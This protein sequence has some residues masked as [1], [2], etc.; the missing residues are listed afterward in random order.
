MHPLYAESLSEFGVPTELSS[1]KGW[2]LVR[3]IAG[4]CDRDALG[5]YPLFSCRNWNGLL[6]DIESLDSELVSLTLVTDPLGDYSVNLLKACF[7]DLLRPFKE[8][9]VIDFQKP[10]QST[11]SRHHRRYARKSLRELAVEAVSQPE[12]FLDEWIELHQHLVKRHGISGIR[13]FSRNA[14]LK[15]FATPGFVLLRARYR[16]R[17]VAAMMFFV[18]GDVAHAHVLGCSAEGYA[19]SALYAI[20]WHTFDFFD[21]SVRWCNLMGV[22]G[23]GDETAENIRR[24]KQ[25]WTQV[26]RTAYLCGRVLNRDKY[27]KLAASCKAKNMSYFPIYRAGELL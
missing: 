5:C 18:Q 24:F 7:P 19:L 14:F 6:Q 12:S 27:D 10:R 17:T 22:P 16:T 15:Q 13:A 9:F 21:D 23:A 4:T 1:S 3:N 25:G 26:T 8:H 2:V 20:I 11:V